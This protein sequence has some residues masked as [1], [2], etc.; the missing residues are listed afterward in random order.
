M[1]AFELTEKRCEAALYIAEGRLTYDQIA[2]RIGV[3]RYTLWEWKQHEEFVELLA[4][5]RER[6]SE[7]VVEHGVAMRILR[8]EMQNERWQDLQRI[9]KARAATE[10]I[11]T[12][13]LDVGLLREFR[14]VEKQA[15]QEAGQWTERREVT[16]P[17]GGPVQ[18]VSV[19][20]AE[21]ADI[22]LSQWQ[23][24]RQRM[25]LAQIEGDSSPTNGTPPGEP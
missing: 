25:L 16:G 17:N 5:H 8:L 4:T 22:K 9:K 7:E 18:T 2:A 3:S 15:A 24:R 11:Y 6:F 20:L 13:E 12:D 14:E 23:E 10:T 19:R 1:C 21:K